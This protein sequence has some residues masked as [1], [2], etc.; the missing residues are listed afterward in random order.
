MIRASAMDLAR[1][2]SC[3]DVV[4]R[5]GH[6][7]KRSGA[8][9]IGACPVCGG[10]DRFAI[11][12]RKNIWN[13]RGCSKGGSVIDLV[14][15]LEEMDF[16]QAIELLLGNI[17]DYDHDRARD[18]RVGNRRGRQNDA[19]DCH[20]SQDH[21]RAE[22]TG[23]ARWFWQW[24]LPILANTPV[25]NYLR[26]ARGYSGVI[27]PTLGYLPPLKPDHHPAL[28]AGCGVPEEPEPGVLAVPDEAI[29]AVHLTLLE[30]DGRGKAEVI[31]N[32]IM[33]GPVSGSPIVVA[34]MND[35]LGLAI[36]EGIEDALAVHAATGLGVWAAGSAPHMPALADAV[37]EYTDAITVVADDNEA[38]RK[39][40]NELAGRLRE[41]GLHVEPLVLGRFG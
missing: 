9:W 6:R 21:E 24:R 41:R 33:I 17:A 19:G 25:W 40:A 2:I 18:H 10:T 14:Q 26:E 5:R 28:I 27:P 30:P 1:R 15:H 11:N 38:G 7:L 37:P 31:P 16:R 8:E 13:C 35:V 22:G 23:K 34:P 39:R 3:A 20:D 32:K 12:T 36:T 4:A 29:M